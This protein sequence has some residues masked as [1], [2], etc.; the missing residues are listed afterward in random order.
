MARSNQRLLRLQLSFKHAVYDVAKYLAPPVHRNLMEKEAKKN[1]SKSTPVE[2]FADEMGLI[3]TQKFLKEAGH[4]IEQD[5][6]YQNV[7]GLKGREEFDSFSK[8]KAQN[9]ALPVDELD[10]PA[11]L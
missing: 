7:L 4:D 9:P 6:V 1:F 3:L 11:T 5:A 2:T 8:I 10:A